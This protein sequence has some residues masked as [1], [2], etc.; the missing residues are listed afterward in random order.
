MPALR[1]RDLCILL[2][3]LAHYIHDHDVAR[4]PTGKLMQ[5]L[6]Q[7]LF[8]RLAAALPKPPPRG[9]NVIRFRAARSL[10]AVL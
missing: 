9:D 5:E 8:R 1:P 4:H 3:A 10:S 7:P 2:H 6:G